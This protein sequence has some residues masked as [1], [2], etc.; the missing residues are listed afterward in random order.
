MLRILNKSDM[1]LHDQWLPFRDK[2]DCL[3]LSAQSGE[4]VEALVARIRV[5]A[6]GDGLPGVEDVVLAHLI[7]A[8]SLSRCLAFIQ[9]ALDSQ[10]ADMTQE[11]LAMDLRGALDAL[12]EIVGNVT[13]D[14]ILNHVFSSFCIG[15]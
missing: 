2:A 4:G 9:Q 5:E 11:F 7:H 13:A 10:S 6:L 8:Q 1:P 14:D 12:G 3:S 15:K